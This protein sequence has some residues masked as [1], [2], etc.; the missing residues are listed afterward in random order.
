MSDLIISGLII[1]AEVA[2]GLGILLLIISATFVLRRR[3]KTHMAEIFTDRLRVDAQG[4]MQ[5]LQ[6][7]LQDAAEYDQ[8]ALD[9]RINALRQQEKKLHEC[10]LAIF[11]HGRPKLLE[12]ASQG[13]GAL[14][15]TSK[16]LFSPAKPDKS[17]TKQAIKLI[18]VLTKARSALQSENQS[19]KKELVS[20]RKEL[21]QLKTEFSAMYSKGRINAN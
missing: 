4:R 14:I 17:K 20:V 15:D 6:Q 18:K 19:L 10:I 8:E 16:A 21:S 11:H 13:L 12:E 5:Q 2:V 3:R 1:A 7:D 9:V